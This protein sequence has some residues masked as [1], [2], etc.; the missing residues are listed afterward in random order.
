MAAKYPNLIVSIY[1]KPQFIYQ[2]EQNVTKLAKSLYDFPFNFDF[3]NS[4]KDQFDSGFALG[5]EENLSLS[6][7]FDWDLLNENA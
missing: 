2:Y 3:P 6:Q 1:Q 5:F 7:Y 4:S